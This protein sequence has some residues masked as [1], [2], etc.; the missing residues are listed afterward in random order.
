MSK[1]V[2]LFSKNSST[3]KTFFHIILYQKDPDTFPES[4]QLQTEDC[5]RVFK[6]SAILGSLATLL[7]IPLSLG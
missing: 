1:K 6:Y 4:R 7:S 5:R 2:H 3:S